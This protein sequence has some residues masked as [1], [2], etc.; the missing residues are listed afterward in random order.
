[1]PPDGFVRFEGGALVHLQPKDKGALRQEWRLDG[2]NVKLVKSGYI[3]DAE[4]S[5]P[6]KLCD[7]QKFL[8]ALPS[9]AGKLPWDFRDPCLEQR[10]S[11]RLGKREKEFAANSGG[12]STR[13]QIVDGYLIATFCRAGVCG[14]YHAAYAVNVRTGEVSAAIESG[15]RAEFFPATAPPEPLKRVVAEFQAQSRD[16]AQ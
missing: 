11:A 3:S 1:M 16:L 10:L 4:L 5:G 12:P 8:A 15:G 7:E 9:Q 13:M 2:A 14:G 6:P